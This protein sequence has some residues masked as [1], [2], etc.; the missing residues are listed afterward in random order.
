M[1]GRTHFDGVIKMTSGPESDGGAGGYLPDITGI[2][3]C[4]EAGK[5]TGEVGCQAE[6]AASGGLLNQRS[7]QTDQR[8]RVANVTPV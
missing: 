6:G 4:V 3:G 8:S 1:E 2:S 5:L 7:E